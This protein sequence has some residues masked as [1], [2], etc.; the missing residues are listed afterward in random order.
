MYVAY[1]IPQ[2]GN[3]HIGMICDMR[4]NNGE[5]IVGRCIPQNDQ[6][7]SMSETFD[8]VKFQRI[9]A[10]I[11]DKQVTNLTSEKLEINLDELNHVR[12]LFEN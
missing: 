2:V 5:L 8:A 11:N 9:M 6:C 4:L 10:I 7:F 12:Y 1:S 3:W